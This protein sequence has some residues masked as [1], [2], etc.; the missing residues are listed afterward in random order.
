[1]PV[2][3]VK[4]R[5]VTHVV[6]LP[7]RQDYATQQRKTANLHLIVKNIH[8]VNVPRVAR[9]RLFS[10]PVLLE[11]LAERKVKRDLRC[12]H[13]RVVVGLALGVRVENR[14]HKSVYIRLEKQ[15]QNLASPA[16]PQSILVQVRL[17]PRTVVFRSIYLSCVVK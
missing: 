7:M 13:Q 6:V 14:P 17:T 4:H 8:A 2:T 12:W 3:A 5:K 9:D 11:M 10:L 15:I 16:H 1:M